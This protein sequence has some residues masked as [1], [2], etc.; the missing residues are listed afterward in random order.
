MNPAGHSG[1]EVLRPVG[2][3]PELAP[4]PGELGLPSRA[5]ALHRLPSGAHGILQGE[6][7]VLGLLAE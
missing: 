4:D 7:V 2:L 5:R 6:D 1:G 3:H